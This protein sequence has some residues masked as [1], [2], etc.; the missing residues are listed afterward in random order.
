M[1][2]TPV[3]EGTRLDPYKDPVGKWTVCTGET[4]VP[5]QHYTVAECNAISARRFKDFLDYT[6]AATP[7][8][9][10]NSYMHAAFGDMAYNNGKAAYAASSMRRLF[11]KGSY[12][13]ACRVILQYK[14]AGGQV[15]PGLVLRRTGDAARIGDYEMCV[16]GA[17]PA[18][19][20]AKGVI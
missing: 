4:E 5:M 18:E 7:G 17:V 15:L 1:Q 16:A 12:R 19:L 13:E 11:A 10:D 8:L 20:K 6:A 3:W 2:L 14:Y 9:A